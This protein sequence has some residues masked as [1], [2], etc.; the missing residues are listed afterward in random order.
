MLIYNTSISKNKA[1]YNPKT[2]LLPKRHLKRSVQQTDLTKTNKAFLKS[3]NFKLKA[4]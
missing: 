3:L 4:K 1:A 2:L